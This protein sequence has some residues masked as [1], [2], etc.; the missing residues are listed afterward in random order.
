MDKKNKGREFNKK[1]V[2]LAFL[3]STFIFLSG[4]LLSYMVTYSKYQSVSA[5]QEE[6]RYQLLSLELEKELLSDSCDFFDPYRFS[7]ELDK[8]GS[9]I[10]ILEER[11]GKYDSKVLKQK[12]IYSM[13]EV[14][15]F[16]LIKENNLQCD[17]KTPVILFFYSN[18]EDFVDEAEKIGRILSTLKNDNSEIMIYSFD[19]D[20]DIN[21][22]NALKFK[23]DIDARNAIVV[24][25]ETLIKNLNNINDI[26]DAL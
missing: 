13:L 25:E 3:V 16:L 22:I 26:K 24:N 20:L 14:Q 10:G 8:M 21:L 5:D 18:L 11:F 4:F 2:V 12:E 23:Y 9:L 15:H 7:K 19:Y 6:I 17:V 1:L